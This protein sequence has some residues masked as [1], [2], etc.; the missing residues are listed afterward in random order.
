[1][2]IKISDYLN[3]VKPIM[4]NLLNELLKEFD[5]VSILGTD[6][7]GK[8]YSVSKNSINIGDG[9]FNERGFVVRV[10]NG[11]NYSEYAFNKIEE[12]EIEGL[13]NK[14]K[15]TAKL[16][17]NITTDIDIKE[18][19]LLLEEKMSFSKTAEIEI[20]PK[21]L[22]DEKILDELIKIK[23]IGLGFNEKIIEC[24]A[25]YK[26]L[27]ISKIF[28]SPNKDLEQGFM[29]GNG[30][31]I[32]ISNDGDGNK[33]GRRASSGAKGAELLQEMKDDIA[34]AAKEAVELLSAERIE[35]GEYEV[36]CTP[37]ITGLITHEAFGHGVEMDMFVKD[38]AKSKD[39]IGKYVAS[40]LVTMHDGAKALL[41]SG[42]YFFDDEGAIASDT[43]II[44]DGILESGIND[45]LTALALNK[46]QTGNGRR[47]SFDRKAYTRM[48]NTFIERGTSKVEDMISSIK[49]GFLIDGCESGMEDP[50]NWGIQCMI[51]LAKEIK[52][53]KFTGRIFSPIIMTGY[54]PDLLKSIS[55]VSDDFGIS[56][57]GY[58]GK[59]YKEWVKVSDG[60]PFIK[61][62]ARLG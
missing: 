44:K 22:G 38:R 60:G 16:L 15:D 25:M 29:W 46:R 40:N 35:P 9:N 39:Y 33:I 37:D 1:M 13:V 11:I 36:I 41:E 53:G 52:D 4:N 7:M 61:C 43:I 17:D 56:G 51:T 10:Y 28:L 48:T 18:Y 26:Y 34:V 55:M 3:K 62:K 6:S 49:Y 47:Q 5:Y 50:K 45:G 24:K 32:C 30:M 8:D 59:G 2:N 54:V 31:C 58:C 14:I 23:D 57:A 21:E 19:E 27:K 42:S 12:N 20:D